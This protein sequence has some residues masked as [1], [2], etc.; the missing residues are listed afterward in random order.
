ME[1]WDSYLQDLQDSDIIKYGV[2]AHVDGEKVAKSSGYIY[3]PN[4]MDRAH[5][6]LL[7]R[8][9]DVQIK[10]QGTT[11]EI[12]KNSGDY[13]M[14]RTVEDKAEAEVMLLSHTKKF[15]V[16]LIAWDNAQMDMVTLE[17]E[18]QYIVDCISGEGY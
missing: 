2:V 3:S 16:A 18:L 13:A 17:K 15:I 10:V 4:E 8:N 1:G 7:D 9:A 12:E 6:L 5:E 11:F 14:G